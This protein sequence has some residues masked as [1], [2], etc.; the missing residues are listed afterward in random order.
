[1]FNTYSIQLNMD[2]IWTTISRMG[3]SGLQ[4][5]LDFLAS[6]YKQPVRAVDDNEKL[7]CIAFPS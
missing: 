4:R 2:G 7:I 6:Q 5:E 1:M 3:N